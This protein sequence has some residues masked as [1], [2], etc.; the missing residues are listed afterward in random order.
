MIYIQEMMIDIQKMDPL[1]EVYEVN[2]LGPKFIWIF[3]RSILSGIL[4][5]KSS[6]DLYVFPSEVAYKAS[7]GL[8]FR[9]NIF[10]RKKFFPCF[11][12]LMVPKKLLKIFLCAFFANLSEI[13]LPKWL[14][15]DSNPQTLST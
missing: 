9:W 15:R 14:Q 7:I 10:L 6:K 2:L 12:S 13:I 5:Y 3:S 11:S 8:R 4:R 1:T